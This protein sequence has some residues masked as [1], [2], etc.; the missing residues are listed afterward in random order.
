MIKRNLR[1]GLKAL[2]VRFLKIKCPIK[3][4]F[5][6]TYRCNNNCSYCNIG[7]IKRTEREL[8][9]KQIK[10]MIGSFA[11]LGAEQITFIG[12]EPLLRRDIGELITYSKEKGLLTAV[13]TNCELVKKRNSALKDLDM[14]ITCLNG[15]QRIHDGMRGKGNYKKVLEIVRSKDIK[16]K[17]IVSCILTKKNLTSIN[18]LLDLA[19]KHN[20]YINF[21]PVFKNELVK[22]GDANLIDELTRE[23]IKSTFN[24][25]VKKKKQGSHILNSYAYLKSF[26]KNG[27]VGFNR[28]YLGLA[29]VTVDPYGNLYRCY[30]YVNENN[31]INGLKLGWRKGFSKI[32]IDKCKICNYGCHIEDNF[33]YSLKPSSIYNLLRM[34]ETLE[35]K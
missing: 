16:S 23:E 15:P 11:D 1:S 26:S 33:L 22:A 9:T 4:N 2:G 19:L 28:C 27:F 35:K 20:F 7:N 10:S 29:S 24:Y 32:K 30:K 5:V 3:I 12:G 13:S 25:L 6:C 31:K 14:L 21:Q 17:K 18:F 34:G 8:N